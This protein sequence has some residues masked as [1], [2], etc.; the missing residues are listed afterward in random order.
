MSEKLIRERNK[1]LLSVIL[2][3]I[4]LIVEKTGILPFLPEHSLWYLP[5]YLIPY[6][7]SGLSVVKECFLGIKNRRPFDEALLMTVATLGAFLSGEFAEAVAVMVFYQMG[8]LFQSYAV[9]KSR[10][11]IKELMDI[12][13]ELAHIEREDG[14]V[15]TVD[16]DE[17]EV[18]DM[19]L[20]KPGER[21]PVDGI[22]RQGESM[23]NTAALTGES[24]P[25]E[26]FP[27]EKIISGCIN[28]E[29]M[30]RVEALKAF[31]DSTVSKILE[32]VEEASEKKS[33]AEN[34]ITKFARIYTPIVVYSALALAILPS[35]G[36]F[37]GTK[38]GLVSP[39]FFAAHPP[40][41]WLY[42]ACTFL[43]VSCPCAVLLRRNRCGF[44]RGCTGKGL[45]LSGAG[46]QIKG[47][48]VR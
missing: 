35:L 19:L 13:P 15:D 43:V 39:E 34:F 5:L 23:V 14:T 41:T 7:L 33:K 44:P 24:V 40:L 11:S 36:L 45:Q 37:L 27:G 47:C 25:R 8:E 18:G 17:V 26:V 30:L 31:E 38:I 42:R 10:K 9:G 22:V 6:F 32:L 4:L 12:V 20:V 46:I 1:L 21:V 28:G 2:F 16:P 3:L 29:G 48:S